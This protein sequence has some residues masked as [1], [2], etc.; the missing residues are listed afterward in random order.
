VN[1][2]LRP[3]SPGQPPAHLPPEVKQLYAARQEL[4][5][6]NAR[7]KVW[8]CYPALAGA[9]IV[10]AVALY[11]L[12]SERDWPTVALVLAAF[13]LTFVA[14]FAGPQFRH[15]HDDDSQAAT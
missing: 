4:D 15:R 3:A 5:R 9:V 12:A 1:D 6:R 8:V 10:L 13:A 2:G 7:F 14:L 11:R